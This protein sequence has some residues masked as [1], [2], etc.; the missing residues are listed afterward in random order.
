MHFLICRS[1]PLGVGLNEDS[2]FFVFKIYLSQDQ[3]FDF[4]GDCGQP[5]T[6]MYFWL[7]FVSGEE[8]EREREVEDK[9]VCL[10]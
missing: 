5:G 8:R 1:L 3:Y 10:I 2:A 7:S 4:A 6:M 9:D